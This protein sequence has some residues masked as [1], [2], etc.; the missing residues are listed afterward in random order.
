M[1]GVSLGTSAPVKL[2]LVEASMRHSIRCLVVLAIVL[3][4]P[5]LVVAQTESGKV[6][7]TVTDQSGAVLPGVTVNLKSV[8][9]ATTR[10]TVTNAQGEYVFASLVPGNYE[11]TAE[12]SGF[13]TKQTRTNVPVGATVNVNVQMAVG[14]QTEVITVVGETQAA[15]NT[16]TQ[17]I[18]TT[19]NETQIRE[20]PTITR[21][22]Y[23][24]VALAGGVTRDTESNRGT[25]YAING[26]RSSSTNILLDGAS[27]NDEFSAT[28]GQA[29]PLDS[30]QE[31]SVITSNFSAQY[32]RASGGVVNVATKSGTNQIRGTVYEFF[33]NDALSTKTFDQK[34]RELPKGEFDRHQFG[35]SLGGPVIKDKLHFFVG[36][37]YIRVRSFDND[38]SLVPTADFLA[39]TAPATQ[40]FFA[41]YSTVEAISAPF[42]T[43]GE[44][45]G[46]PGGAFSQ[47][48]RDLPVFGRVTQRI[49]SNAG[50]GDPIDDRQLVGRL[51][52]A[53]SA[54]TTAY[55]RYAYQNQEALDAANANSPYKGFNTSYANYN[56]SLLGSLTHVFSSSLTSQTKFVYN[57]LN[58]SQPLGEQPAGPTLYMRQSLTTIQGDKV[59]LP[60]Y[61]PYNPGSAIPFGGPQQY[62]QFYQDLNLV[63]GAHDL[64]FGGSITHMK[65]DRTFGA[66][67]NSVQTLGTSL[68]GAL[69]NLVLGRQT[70]FNGA[71]DPQ[72]AL[73]GGTITLPATQPSFTRNNRYWEWSLY[74]NDTWS[75]TP[76]L[77]VNLGLRYE[78]F[79]P[80]RNTDRSL[81]SNFYPGS[82]ANIFEQTRNGS[83]QIAQDSP[84]G[85]LWK[86]SSNNFAPR[87]GFAWDVTGDGKTSLRGGY[88]IGYERNFGNVTFNVI[89]NP[90]NYGVLSFV[91]TAAA[92]LP[93]YTSNFGPLEGTGTRTLPAVTLRA[94]NPDIKQSYAHFWSLSLQRELFANTFGSIDY[95][96]SAGR[97]LYDIY[98][99]NRPYAGY[100]SGPLPSSLSAF[101]NPNDRPNPQYGNI[102]FRDDKGQSIYHG[103]TFGLE[104]R[105]LGSTGLQFSARYTL[106]SAKDYLSSTFVEGNNNSISF[107]AYLDA[108]NP[109][110]D[111]G[112]ADFDVR[113]RFVMGGIWEIPLA[114][115]SGGATK[116]LLGD[117]QFN[118]I[119]SAQTGTPFSMY[120]CTNGFFMCSRMNLVGPVGAYTSE[121]VSGETNLFKYLD[122]GNQA[123]GAGSIADRNGVNETAP[124]GGYPASLSKRGEF[125]RPGRWNV[126]ASPPAAVRGVQPV[127]PREPVPGRR[128]DRHLGGHH[129]LRGQG[130]HQQLRP[131]RRRPAPHPAR[132]EV[133]VLA[134]LEARAPASF[135]RVVHGGSRKAPPVL[136]P[137]V[138]P[139]RFG[140]SVCH[141]EELRSRRATR[142]PQS[143]RVPR[144]FPSREEQERA[145]APRTLVVEL[146]SGLRAPYGIP[147]AS[148]TRSP[149][150]SAGGLFP[151]GRPV[152]SLRTADD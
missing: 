59:A 44:L 85:D 67:Q 18:A 78:F 58:N 151:Q 15:I 74:F 100:L 22:A 101:A 90:P 71:I 114:R 84:Q 6:S 141:P 139:R 66:Y 104:S 136:S 72:G 34:A 41:P 14:A 21:N 110:L 119:F 125:R 118:W 53:V 19:V 10:S 147:Q 152:P 9:R 4:I 33:R 137:V 63:S 61:L 64:R 79:G 23:D 106:S 123:G 30:V 68:A 80:Q 144:S 107:L 7:G 116:A 27:N 109:S 65:D 17:D 115:D 50:G 52:W 13:S 129:D 40:A 117:W 28:V 108:L 96:G 88:G 56:H 148:R 120:D 20:L 98:N 143:R 132:G 130:R 124:D 75:V 55:F 127:Q 122:L 89:Q 12:L 111:E 73:P 11:V 48:P 87:V 2:V 69:D 113:H 83:V 140:P 47:L 3:M 77:K 49:P 29:V 43:A 51:D 86:A 57:K 126:D 82:G 92:P 135:R 35:F 131:H 26:Q 91:G 138:V 5:A 150:P 105:R 97:H 16:S 142:D 38:V 39:R 76:R 93:I 62:F 42:I 99:I 54:S 36:G 134:S 37:E 8:E 102:N 81:D 94:V 146:L 133:R 112:Y 128:R 32:G 45:A 46:A 149:G 31:F 103:V 24:L 1:V 70:Q 121:A 95:T 145:R 25:G 60:G